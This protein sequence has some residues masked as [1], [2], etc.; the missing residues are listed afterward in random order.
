MTDRSGLPDAKATPVRAKRLLLI[1][2]LPWLFPARLASELQSVGF[3]VEIVCRR[4]SPLLHLRR[5]PKHYPLN[6]L[7]ERRSVARAIRASAPDWVI[8]CDDPAIDVLH[9][10]YDRDPKGD[11]ADLLRRSLGHPD[12]FATVEKRSAVLQVARALGVHVPNAS[13]FAG[14]RALQG[15]TYPCVLKWDRSWGGQGVRIAHCE[16]ELRAYSG[17]S[18]RMRGFMRTVR[19]AYDDRR[20][21]HLVRRPGSIELQAFVAGAPANRAVLCSEGRVIA[22]H[23]V[24]ALETAGPTEPA[25]VVMPVE[26]EGMNTATEAIVAALRLSG[27][28]GF[29]FILPEKGPP[30]FLELNARPTPI[31]HIT[32]RDGT[33]L[34]SALCILLGGT[35]PAKRPAQAPSGPMLL[36]GRRSERFGDAL[37]R[38]LPDDEPGLLRIAAGGDRIGHET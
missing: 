36:F 4:D 26:N 38:D 6:T 11:M 7:A 22:G 1:S 19:V 8:P 33:H 34:P 18:A 12:F 31:S 17:M 32:A 37:Q 23:S 15:V 3:E 10:L 24:V 21:L 16:S 2:L 9:R 25:T 29:D 13:A 27:F 14:R 20:L 28:C 35:P 5:Q 30:Y